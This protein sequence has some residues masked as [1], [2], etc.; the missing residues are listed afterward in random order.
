MFVILTLC[1]PRGIWRADRKTSALIAPRDSRGGGFLPLRNYRPLKLD[2]FCALSLAR[3]LAPCFDGA[4]GLWRRGGEE[5]MEASERRSNYPAGQV[6]P[7]RARAHLIA[8]LAPSRFVSPSGSGSGRGGETR[9]G[10]HRAS[11][12][13]SAIRLEAAPRLSLSRERERARA[14]E[15]HKKCAGQTRMIDDPAL[16]RDI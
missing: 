7:R 5:K 15:R 13:A 9:R 4:I 14:L 8:A 2:G 16:A 12:S 6:A 11:S 3:Q 10:Q 1:R